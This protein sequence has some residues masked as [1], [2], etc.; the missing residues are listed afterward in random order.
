MYIIFKRASKNL[1]LRYKRPQ[2]KKTE[3]FRNDTTRIN[4]KR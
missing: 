1:I 4:L 3:Y 2:I